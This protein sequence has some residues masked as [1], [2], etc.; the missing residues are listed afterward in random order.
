MQ[1][2]GTQGKAKRV[3]L[4]AM[5]TGLSLV[6]LYGAGLMP[7][8]RL[9]LTAVAGLFPAAVVTAFGIPAGFLCYA[10]TGLLALLLVTDKGLALLYLLFFGLYPMVKGLA[11]QGGRRTVEYGVKVIFFNGIFS[12]FLFGMRTVFLSVIPW[13]QIPLW[14]LY[15]GGNVAFLAYDFGFSKLICFYEKRI[16]RVLRN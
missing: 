6:F 5:L 10:G 11:E 14:G 12:L 15:L 4:T 7:S 2:R 16:G 3:A 9:G 8:G 1:R 13:E